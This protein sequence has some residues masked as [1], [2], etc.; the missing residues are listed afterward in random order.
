MFKLRVATLAVL[1][2]ACSPPPPTERAEA[3]QQIRE[4]IATQRP[5]CSNHRTDGSSSA[6]HLLTHCYEQEREWLTV[7]IGAARSEIE[8][9]DQSALQRQF[10][11]LEVEHEAAVRKC[12]QAPVTDSVTL[13]NREECLTFAADR[14]LSRSVSLL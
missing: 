13:L 11:Q 2:A 4:T 9:R 8:V 14:L 7:M 5:T 12:E 1:L 3:A 6:D 10:A